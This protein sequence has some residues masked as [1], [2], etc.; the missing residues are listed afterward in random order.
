[1][2]VTFED[3]APPDATEEVPAPKTERPKTATCTV[4]GTEFDVSPRGR[5]PSKCP[6]HRKNGGPGTSSPAHR[7][8]SGLRSLFGKKAKRR[9]KS[10]RSAEAYTESAAKLVGGVVIEP[11]TIVGFGTR[12]PGP[13]ATA[14]T[15]AYQ[16]HPRYEDDGTGAPRLVGSKHG[17]LPE[18]LGE[19]ATMHPALAVVLDNFE[20][21]VPYMK[22]TAAI[23]PIVPQTLANFGVI[24]PGVL[25]TADPEMIATVM[26]HQATQAMSEQF[27]NFEAEF[28]EAAASMNGNGDGG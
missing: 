1:M 13:L 26:R 8:P 20:T 23:L 5:V 18:A 27:I 16:C 12:H 4:C 7:K 24:K 11:L 28:A 19:L 14:Y 10:S 2:E 9:R 17:P 21:V 25:N 3:E 22:L 15:V 6:E